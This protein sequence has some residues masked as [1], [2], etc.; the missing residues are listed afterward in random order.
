MSST[1]NLKAVG[2]NYSPNQ[3]SVP[4]GSLSQTNNVI[5]RRDAVIEP[6]RG[7]HLYGSLFGSPTDRLNQ[8]LIY[9]NTILAQYNDLLLFDS[10]GEGTLEQF[11]GTY[12]EVI[13]GLR[14]KSVE[15]SGNFYFTTATGVKKI[16]AT[17]ASQFTTN[18]GYITNAGGVNAIDFTATPV[19]DGISGFLPQD[20]VVEYRTLWGTT[21]VNGLLVLGSPSPPI[22]VYNPLLNLL[23]PNYMQFL[24]ALD[25]IAVNPTTAFF[26]FADYTQT[27]GVPIGST[28]TT[29]YNK[30]LSLV[31]QMDNDI[32]YENNTGTG[33]VGPLHITADATCVVNGFVTITFS[34]GNPTQ[35]FTV[36]G[37]V[38]SQYNIYLS[39][40]G[41]GSSTSTAINGARVISSVTATTIVFPVTGVTTSDTFAHSNT[42]IVSD[43]FRSIVPPAVP[44]IPATNNDNVNLQTYIKAIL[45]AIETEP[46]TVISTAAQAFFTP[47]LFTTTAN[48]ILDIDIPQD[49]TSNYFL[50]IYRSNIL[51]ATGTT[52]LN[53]LVPNDE[54][55]QVYEAY[56]TQAQLT[57]G[58]MIVTDITPDAFKGANLYTNQDTGVGIVQSNDV[59]PICQDLAMFKNVIFYANTIRKESI[60]GL[61]LL[62]I[63]NM[64]ADALAGIPP[65]LT[66]ASATSNNTYTFVL[67][68]AQVEYITAVHDV[69][70]S[71]NGTYFTLNS[72]NNAT[73]YYVWYKTSGG[74]NSDPAPAGKTGIK[75]YIPTG[76]TA[77]QIANNTINA[78]SGVVTDFNSAIVT[79]A[80][81]SVTNTNVGITTAAADG[82][83]PT[84]FTFSVHTAGAGES[85]AN[86]QVLLSNSSSPAQA[87]TVT[88][89]SLIRVINENASEVIYGFY[90]S[91]LTSVPGVMT[92]QAREYGTGPFYLITN[93]TDTGSSF[94]PNLSPEKAITGGNV[95]TIAN[96]TVLKSTS[97]GLV[98]NQQIIITGSNST[99]SINGIYSITVIDANDFSI[100]VN[101]TAVP[102]TQTFSYSLLTDAEVST[103]ETKPNRIYYSQI[104]EPE[105]VS[106]V[107]FLDIGATNKKILRIF[108]LRDTLFVFKED[109]LFRIT[110]ETAPWYVS[111]FDSSC[112][113][114][115]A[116]S[117]SVANNIIYAY[118]R[119]GISTIT[120]AGVQTV[121]RPIDTTII[122]IST[123]NYP[124][125]PTAT[126]GI[127]YESDN[128]YL[129]GTVSQTTDTEATIIYRYS[130]LTNSWT[131]WDKSD[132][133]GII[134]P[135]D[136]KLYMG[137][138]DINSIEQERKT[139]TR[140]DY[141]DRE[142]DL[143]ISTNSVNGTNVI[144]SSVSGITEGDVLV[145][146]QLLTPYTFNSLLQKLD[147]DPTVAKVNISTITQIGM[148]VTIT[149]SGANNLSTSFPWVTIQN[150]TNC[151]PSINGTYE[152]Q[153][154]SGNTFNII[155]PV[156]VT[157]M[158]T[159]NGQARFNYTNNL[160][161]LAGN[162][163]RTSLINFAA[164]LDTDPNLTNG[165]YSS[166]IASQSGYI[167]GYVF[168]VS[169]ANATI[170]AIYHNNGNNFTVL[171]TIS[172]A[173]TLYCSGTANPSVSGTLTK[174]SGTGD[175]TITFSKF[176]YGISP[177]F[178]STITSINHQLQNGRLI[179]IS[180]SD[181]TPSVN[182]NEV[183]TILNSNQFSI[184]VNVNTGG[185]SGTW[186][187][188]DN[189][190]I[191]IQA[192]Y[193]YIANNLNT[194]TGTSF[195]NY[196]TT[197]SVTEEEAVIVAVNTNTK[198]VTLN[199]ALPWVV[200]SVTVFEAIDSSFTYCPTTMN[201]PLGYKHL[202]EAT[203]M[204]ENK[205]F[206]DAT[207][208]FAT[209][210]LPELL[211][212]DC[213]GEGNGIFGIGTG[214]F[215]Q[216]YFGG[217]S[218]PVPFRTYI[219]RNC[220]RC[221]YIVVQFDH[222]IAREKY[223]IFGISLTG[224]ISQSTRAYR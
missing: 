21:D 133:C 219:P 173:T 145:Q 185:N 130:N 105:A 193:N 8:L 223:S 90:S 22:A 80:Q 152:A 214:N 213:P 79:G 11:A 53:T 41:A 154:I 132:T 13:P 52:V 217:N 84:G 30:L 26:E 144:L 203:V 7:L 67:G 9:K 15:A 6:R 1:V 150:N 102:G 184:P 168:T 157:I 65:T 110:G 14:M 182:G 83:V 96:P 158:G 85:A 32:I 171:S 129:L 59:P 194:D 43:Q 10:D 57:A 23:I 3:L 192:C 195:K 92:L 220:Q 103:A 104:L 221:R 66:I 121:S 46:N 172:G 146:D 205:A 54:L 75:V 73:G 35:Y 56:P 170:G 88:A 186:V 143:T 190:F 167:T 48:V 218:H 51:Q 78:I 111:L 128:S 101:V 141:A 207:L 151:L 202:S 188:D 82:T 64:I 166:G 113:L 189:N 91:S 210:L 216:G 176:D 36:P 4:D 107:N 131:T 136:D 126:W 161:V 169:S 178:P 198:T 94:S 177:T 187:T 63:T 156:P 86:K 123:A 142:T 68:A 45:A 147:I 109:G 181:S 200:G 93:N 98:N 42:T 60:I 124:G 112:I 47:I 212:V 108:P 209:D 5:I 71:L 58:Q 138:G 70:N 55:Q 180:G 33:T 62:G 39:G 29:L 95:I 134:N 125:F 97:H 116:D 197:S 87:V 120:E 89:Q 119:Q 115:A 61:E 20:S 31:V 127:G 222:D 118:T 25:N 99:P 16:S 122:P 191:D 148:T 159:I 37:S 201:D 106:L 174:T 135:G 155:V 76:A 137:A 215:G 40:F 117:V 100:P 74:S 175:S 153:S 196:L 2:L 27:Y 204:F 17:S 34:T 140:L 163:L 81:F 165:D 72:A 24:N 206:T 162:N 12:E 199:V 69:S 19:A 224:N 183:V 211:S 28:A 208:S 44:N 38:G 114:I 149:T 49:I 160:E 50:Q 139:F 179:T 77:A 18:S 164:K